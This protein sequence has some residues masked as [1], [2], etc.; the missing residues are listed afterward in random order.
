MH[1]N[2]K[3]TFLVLPMFLV[4]L[5]CS[6][7]PET[8]NVSFSLSLPSSGQN[9]STAAGDQLMHVAINVTG[10]GITSPIIFSWDGHQ[11]GT[12]LAAPSSFA[13][14]VAQGDSRLVQVLAVYQNETS[15]TMSFTYGD[16]TTAISGANVALTITMA[17]IGA[18]SS[19]QGQISGRYLTGT[20][21]GPTG[22]IDVNFNPGGGKRSLIIEKSFM[23]NGWFSV[24]SLSG[25]Q[26]EYMLNGTTALFG[27]PVNLESAAFIP[28]AGNVNQVVRA[29]LPT[30][31]RADGGGGTK[32]FENAQIYIWGFWNYGGDVSA[33]SVCNDLSA[34]AFSKI[35]RYNAVPASANTLLTLSNAAGNVQTYPAYANLL[36]KVSPLS[37]VT[38]GGGVGPTCASSTPSLNVIPVTKALIDGNGK[39]NSAGFRNIFLNSATGS[40]LTITGTGTT[41][42][43]TGSVLPGISSVYDRI[44][45]YKRIGTPNSNFRI[46]TPFCKDIDSGASNFIWVGEAT[47]INA[48]TGAFSASNVNIDTTSS[49]YSDGSVSIVACGASGPAVA[50]LAAVGMF[51]EVYSSGGGGGGGNLASKVVLKSPQ[52]SGSSG[53]I[54]NSTCTPL[55]IEGQDGGGNPA[56]LPGATQL[57]LS[58]PGAFILYTDEWCGTP[59]PLNPSP[60]SVPA[61]NT[62]K[63][64][65]KHPATG[66]VDSGSITYSAN[67]GL[68]IAG[69]LALTTDD[70]PGTLTKKL[71]VESPISIYAHSCLPV[72]F[73]SWHDDGT[74]IGKLFWDVS[75]GFTLPVLSGLS[76][77]YDASCAT[78][79]AT[80][81]NLS[82]SQ[83]EN[84]LFFKYTGANAT[85]NL[86]PNPVGGFTMSGATAVAVNQPG[87]PTSLDL[88]LPM[89]LSAEWC[90]AVSIDVVDSQKHLTPALANTTIN[91]TYDGSGTPATNS[92]FY[93]DSNCTS[94]WSPQQITSGT[95]GISGLYFRWTNP[96]ASVVIAATTST[97]YTMPSLTLNVGAVA[98]GRI[99]P[100]TSGA[101]YD[102]LSDTYTG[103][104][105]AVR[106]GQ[107]FPL[108]LAA[109]SPMGNPIIAFNEPNTGSPGV[110]I[111]YSFPGLNCGGISWTAGI[112]NTTC[113]YSGA[114]GQFTIANYSITTGGGASNYP[115]FYGGSNGAQ[116][117]TVFAKGED[118]TMFNIFATQ[119]FQNF[120]AACQ[121]ILFSRGASSTNWGA[122][123]IMGAVVNSTFSYTFPATSGVYSGH[124]SDAACTVSAPSA[125]LTA[126]ESAK[127]IYFKMTSGAAASNFNSN[128]DTLYNISN[129]STVTPSA[130]SLGVFT[131]YKLSTN[132][133][134]IYGACT[135]LMIVRADANGNGVAAGGTETINLSASDFSF[136]TDATC[137]N[138]TPTATVAVGE[139]A[140]LVFVKSV[141][142]T[143]TGLTISATNAG[144]ASETG[145]VSVNIHPTAQP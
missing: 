32:E 41:A 90:Q 25:V 143:G 8:S 20:D 144:G 96:G 76:F 66:A 29:A 130:G 89:N 128:F 79:P 45:F 34:G 123:Q 134:Q 101:T 112:G 108:Q 57:I 68:S 118:T 2:I 50:D 126:G 60:F 47:S 58:A 86:Q 80:M 69:P 97:G 35:F 64:W 21:S 120:T 88:K 3:K 141:N 111:Q 18:G 23:A 14:D 84:N 78:S 129:G 139:K 28:A 63:L 17:P 51:Q 119:P 140:S 39:D 87:A 99:V 31:V 56:T 26:F 37:A 10:P 49:A 38:A 67:N 117:L 52:G 105:P 100:V 102:Y 110:N 13:F 136:Y 115:S 30:M 6:R 127:I 70:V 53:F 103:Y 59:A 81:V 95:T 121:P 65:V 137:T 11:N 15:G 104:S 124:Y 125:G 106:D 83:M 16:T 131:Q 77:H 5:A 46:D 98:L 4:T 75:Q 22:I 113:S 19:V 122:G 91:F 1:F 9:G 44:K 61:G 116:I 54:F 93:T 114:N 85:I 82:A 43:V 133:H 94:P 73:S 40:P 42:T 24:F 142:P 72:S 107:T 138:L 74:L 109:L 27:G 55:Q 7:A 132:Q 33:K 135:P 48:G 92:G 12:T 71:V 62:A 36:D 145:S